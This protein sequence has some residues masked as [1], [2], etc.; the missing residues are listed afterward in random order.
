MFRWLFVFSIATAPGPL[1]QAQTVLPV[2][3][4]QFEHRFA[5]PLILTPH[6]IPAQTTGG[7]E[8]KSGPNGWLVVGVTTVGGAVLCATT[9]ERAFAALLLGSTN[10]S[11]WLERAALGAVSGAVVGLTVCLA[12]HCDWSK[13]KIPHPIRGAPQ[14]A[15]LVGPTRLGI[16][17]TW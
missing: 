3:P 6:S 2:L 13:P 5:R 15:V 1:A 7:Q 8:A 4:A 11:T 9:C 14:A 17:V 12:L 16:R 10:S